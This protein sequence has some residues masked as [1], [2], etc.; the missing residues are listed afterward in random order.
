MIKTDDSGIDWV[1]VGFKVIQLESDGGSVTFQNLRVIYNYNST[2]DDSVGFGDYLRQTVAILGQEQGTSTQSYIPL[3]STSQ[4][5]GQLH[6]ANLQIETAQGYDSTLDF[7]TGGEGL[8]QTGEIYHF[9]STHNVQAGTGANLDGARLQF[10]GS[11]DSLY[12]GY[13]LDTGFYELD[14]NSDYVSLHPSSA[15]ISLPNGEY[16]LTGNSP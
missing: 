13:D 14:D 9:K 6:L 11:S 10:K 1:R 5:G 2:L 3:T 4:T 16:K 15:V 7:I 12:L 8:Y